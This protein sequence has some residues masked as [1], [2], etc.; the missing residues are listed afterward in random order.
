MHMVM[1]YGSKMFAWILIDAVCF[2]SF[3]YI[4][5]KQQV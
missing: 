2:V 3:V 5:R 1:M 4:Y